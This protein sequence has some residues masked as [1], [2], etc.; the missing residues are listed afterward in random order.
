VQTFLEHMSVGRTR[1][2]CSSTVGPVPR[3]CFIGQAVTM[4]GTWTT[5]WK[6]GAV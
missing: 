5:G 1:A 2:A 4:S 3:R 6:C